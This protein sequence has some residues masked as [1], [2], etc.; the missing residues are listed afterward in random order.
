MDSQFRL[1]CISN[2]K[3]FNFQLLIIDIVF[4]LVCLFGMEFSIQGLLE[5]FKIYFPHFL[6]LNEDLL[7]FSQIE[8]PWRSE[9]VAQVSARELSRMTAQERAAQNAD[10]E[11]RI[12]QNRILA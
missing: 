4:L 8:I 7:T 6:F 1:E 12:L 10:M 5:K 9:Q 11:Q 3:D 2:Y